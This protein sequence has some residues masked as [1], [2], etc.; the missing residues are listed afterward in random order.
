MVREMVRSGIAVGNRM[1]NRVNGNF[2]ILVK[3]KRRSA[4]RV[5]GGVVRGVIGVHVFRSRGNGAGLNL[6]RIN[7]DLLLVSRFALCTSYGEK[8]EPSFVE[9]KTPSVTR[10]LCGCVVTE[11][12]RRVSV[13][14]RKRFKTSVGIR[15]I[16]SNPF[17]IVLSD[18]RLWLSMAIRCFATSY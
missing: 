17:A 5:T 3:M 8:G 16:G 10:G 13:I 2:V 1:Q 11:Y 12:G 9:T 18:G 15:L 6:G 14:R 7:K 4:I